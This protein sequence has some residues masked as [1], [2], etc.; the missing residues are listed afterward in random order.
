MKKIHIVAHTHWDREWYF[1][2]NEAFVQFSYHMDEVIYALD[3]NELDYYY[4][5][6]QLSIV[7]DYLKIFPNKKE[8]IKEL[9]EAKKLFIGPWYTQM[10]EFVV[11]GESVVKNLQIG[12]LLSEELGGYTSLGYL[13]D[14]FGQ[15]KDM[16][17]IYQGFD[18]D[19]A[20][21]WR[22]MPSEITNNRE[23]FWEAEDGS[24]V[25][26]INIRNGYYAGVA[27]VEGDRFLQKSTLD[28]VSED[29]I[30]EIVTLPVGGDQRAVDRQLKE[31]IHQANQELGEEYELVESNYPHIFKLLEKSKEK[32][33]TVSG[34]FISGSVSKIHR[35]IYSSRYDLK[36]INDTIENRLIFELQPLAAMADEMGIPYKTELIDYIWKLLL[37]NHAHDSIGGCNTDKTNQMIMARYQ[38]A[39][40]L[41]YSNVDYLVRKIS[42]SLTSTRENDI[43]L[44]NTMPYQRTEPFTFKISSKSKAISLVDNEDNIVPFEVLNV[45]KVYAGEIRRS[46]KDYQEDLYYYIYT[47]AIDYSLAAFNYQILHVNEQ[48]NV[49]EPSVIG[50]NESIMIENDY[51]KV[52]F[53]E[54]AFDITSKYNQK[55]YKNCLYVEE[56]GDEGDTY[57]YS[58]A[59]HDMILNLSFSDAKATVQ[60]GVIHSTIW[61]EGTWQ[62]PQSLSSRKNGLIDQSINYKLEVSVKKATNRIE[63]KL[64][65]NNQADDHRMRLVFASDI[66]SEFSYADT[67]FGT[68]ERLNVDPHINDWQELGWKEEP[69]EIYPMIH[70][71]NIHDEMASVSMLSKGI[72]EYQ[73]CDNKLFMT[74]FRGVGYLGRPEL[75]RRP[76]DASGNQFRYIPT[77]DSQLHGELV[78]EVALVIEENYQ[79]A[80]IQKNYQM[81]SVET[82]Y[83]QLQEINRFTNPIKYFQ[84]N[85]VDHL[86]ALTNYLDL[87]TSSLVFSSLELSRDG[88]WLEIRLNNPSLTDSIIETIQLSDQ[89]EVKWINLYGKSIKQL[90]V[91]KSIEVQMKPGEIKTFA[92]KRKK[93]GIK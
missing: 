8:K 44:F 21:F 45:E 5:D 32:L 76:G 65:I 1:S 82:P 25:L 67:L 7:E 29:T 16:P 39:D 26:T 79:P 50:N 15:G 38:E 23:F 61:I 35:S 93:R 64:V 58:P 77:P 6:G 84:S 83:Y 51:Y 57:D 40:Q 54:G 20:V 27:L 41:S 4:L 10:D 66:A 70:F 68:I 31:I 46:E 59:Y 17:K 92:I 71:A 11:A 88:E 52:S 87:A 9:V 13:P 75:L 36:K 63:L 3:N 43:V 2:D 12:M 90:G 74:L 18:I 78:M 85:K 33:P 49:L 80:S 34:E 19:H 37:K 72:K 53:V 86:E 69:T 81:Y 14:S 22:G 91:I 42:E 28:L 62:V 24:K 47:V 55:V 89:F 56:S 73:V 30:S 48:E 60:E